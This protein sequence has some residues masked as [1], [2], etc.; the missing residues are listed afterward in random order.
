MRFLTDPFVPADSGSGVG[1][2]QADLRV[3]WLCDP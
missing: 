1:V 3:T 2:N